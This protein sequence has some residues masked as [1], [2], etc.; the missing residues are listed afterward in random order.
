MLVLQG[1]R[2]LRLGRHLLL[3]HKGLEMDL[4]W[5]GVKGNRLWV[6]NRLVL[7]CLRRWLGQGRLGLRLRWRLLLLD[8]E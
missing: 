3:V 7:G 5:H 6:G 2:W 1:G 4:R 8:N